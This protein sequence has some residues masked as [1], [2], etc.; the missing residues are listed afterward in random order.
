MIELIKYDSKLKNAQQQPNNLSSSMLRMGFVD[1]V[2][3]APF[4]E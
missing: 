1:L 2:M 3:N 4:K